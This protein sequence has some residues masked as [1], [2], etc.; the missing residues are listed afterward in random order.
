MS[1]G[2]KAALADRLAP[3]AAEP[4]SNTLAW[5]LPLFNLIRRAKGLP[6][7]TLAEALEE[8]RRTPP[9]D[10]RVFA[11]LLDEARSRVAEDEARLC[12]RES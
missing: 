1:G 6:P 12:G 11:R 3:K 4:D 7:Q 9:V 8:R 5:L 2:W 10:P